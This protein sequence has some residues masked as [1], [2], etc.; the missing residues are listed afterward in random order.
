MSDHENEVLL[1][2]G[3]SFEIYDI[4]ECSG[5]TFVRAVQVME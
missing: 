4:I 3:A 1:R 5:K 2:H